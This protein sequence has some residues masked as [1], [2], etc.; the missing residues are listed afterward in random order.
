MPLYLD[1]NASKGLATFIYGSCHSKE[2]PVLFFTIFIVST[3]GNDVVYT[4]LLERPTLNVYLA[5]LR[6]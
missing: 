2:K 6:Y 1:V 4:K 3:N 5:A